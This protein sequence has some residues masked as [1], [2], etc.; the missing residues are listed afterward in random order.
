MDQKEQ[1]ANA[2]S[3]DI[4]LFFVDAPWGEGKSRLKPKRW[5]GGYQQ[6]KGRKKIWNPHGIKKW[7]LS[8]YEDVANKKPGN[9]H[10]RSAAINAMLWMLCRSTCRRAVVRCA[11][12]RRRVPL[13]GGCLSVPRKHKGKKQR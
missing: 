11:A 4:S 3:I 5:S 1:T 2:S 9:H 10:R 13:S 7:V 6:K 8:S 12:T